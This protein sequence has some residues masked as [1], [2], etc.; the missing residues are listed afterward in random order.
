MTKFVITFKTS[1][2]S[3]ARVY[4]AGSTYFIDG[5]EYALGCSAFLGGAKEFG[6]KESAS[7]QANIL[8]WRCKNVFYPKV[9][10]VRDGVGD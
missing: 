1:K 6:K 7:R 8:A 9:E 3:T 5:V 10:E 2:S 4:F